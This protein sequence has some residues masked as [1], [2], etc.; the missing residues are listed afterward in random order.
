MLNIH[1]VTWAGLFVILLGTALTLYG[2]DE[3]N[4]ESMDDIKARD[5]QNITIT[6]NGHSSFLLLTFY[7]PFGRGIMM[8]DVSPY[9]N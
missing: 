2:Q 4:K 6:N 8:S 5:D 9:N 1:M 3:K 7:F